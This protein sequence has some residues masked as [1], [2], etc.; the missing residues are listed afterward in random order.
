MIKG[1]ALVAGVAVVLV[2]LI[3][4]GGKVYPPGQPPADEPVTLCEQVR[5]YEPNQPARR[6]ICHPE[7]FTQPDLRSPRPK[8]VSL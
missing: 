4:L 6:Y 3:V 5:Q 7:E 8:T 1:V 2:V